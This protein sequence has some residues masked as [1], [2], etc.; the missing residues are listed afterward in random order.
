LGGGRNVP[1]SRGVVKEVWYSR[2]FPL[3]SVPDLLSGDGSCT[4][5]TGGGGIDTIVPLLIPLPLS[6]RSDVPSRADVVEEIGCGDE[7][8][9]GSI[10]LKGCEHLTTSVPTQ[11]ILGATSG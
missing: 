9:V 2:A 1:G 7:S 11:H 4:V 6:F 5:R 10:E 8:R 3:L